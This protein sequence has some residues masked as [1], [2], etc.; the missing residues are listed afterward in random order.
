MHLR[1][2]LRPGNDQDL[3][4]EAGV[5]VSAGEDFKPKWESRAHYWLA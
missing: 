2:D 5:T 3:L 1:G 4:L